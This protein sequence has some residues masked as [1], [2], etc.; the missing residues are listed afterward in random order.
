[1][2]IDNIFITFISYKNM[3]EIFQQVAK[4]IDKIVQTRPLNFDEM[5][6]L[7]AAEDGSMVNEGGGGYRGCVSFNQGSIETKRN[8]CFWWR[9]SG[10]LHFADNEEFR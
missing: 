3:D 8:F 2:A 9:T 6:R 10:P 1:M 5:V 7:F 4:G